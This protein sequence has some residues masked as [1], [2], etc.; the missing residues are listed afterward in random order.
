MR[1]STNMLYDS[2]V[3]GIQQREQ[4]QLKLQQQISSGSRIVS[5]SDDPVAAAAALDVKQSIALNTQ[6][7]ANGDS[8]KSQLGLEDNALSDL[9]TLLQ[10]V[11]TLAVNAGNPA[12]SNADRS[13]LATELDGR[14]QELIGIA[15]RD[16]GNGNYLFS[17]Y[18]GATKPFVEVSAG[19]VTY[20]GDAGQRLTQIGTNRTIATNDS[21]DSVFRSIRTG[22]GT[23]T[24]SAANGNTGGGVI[25]AGVV[26]D[27]SK[28][29]VA[30]NAR[31]FSIKFDVTGGV[32]TYDI[33]DN[34]N[35]VS[36]LTGA[37]PAAGPYLRTFV[38]GG[39]IS[40]ATQAPPDTNATPF[41]YGAAVSVSGAPNSGDSFNIHA[42][43]RQDMFATLH[44]LVTTL[45]TGASAT[46][47]STAAYQGGV[48]AALSNIDNALN[49][50]L[51]VRASVGARLKEVD[52]AQSSSENVSL[53]Y[54]KTLSDLQ[55]LDYTK[56][57]SDLSQQ[58]V[59]LQ[60]AQQSFLRITKLNLFEML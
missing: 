54:T 11:K 36:L 45:Q 60:A 26:S 14:Y 27:P 17:G 50:V 53:Q 23:F 33:V 47:A 2:G 18:Q 30:G 38:P 39:A 51:T 28:W 52:N 43:T 58:Q 42:S 31:N 13:S 56:A 57:I 34:V 55:D 48:N 12:L 21:G 1:I 22:N 44:N 49:N 37:A 16:D 41:D 3:A 8:V 15:N 32:T 35:N 46:A 40:L 29:N 5:P 59:T 7:H 25:D 24:A 4:Q 10:D 9:T 20:N 19:N 6:L